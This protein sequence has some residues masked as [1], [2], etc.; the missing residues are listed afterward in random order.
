MGSRAFCRKKEKI[1]TMLFLFSRMTYCYCMY[2]VLLTYLV[3]WMFSRIRTY[4][5]TV[6]RI[7]ACCLYWYSNYFRVSLSFPCWFSANHCTF[8]GAETPFRATGNFILRHGWRFL[9]CTTVSDLSLQSVPPCQDWPWIDR[10]VRKLRT[11]MIS[12]LKPRA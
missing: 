8:P 7:D 10:S 2:S 9:C 5:V 3:E 6:V 4:W 1:L 12:F 11:A